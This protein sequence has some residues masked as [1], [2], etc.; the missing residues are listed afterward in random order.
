M[1]DSSE[2]D[3]DIFRDV[4]PFS[5]S[6]EEYEHDGER[7]SLYFGNGT[8]DVA[9]VDAQ[10]MP[11]SISMMRNKTFN[12]SLRSLQSLGS[13]SVTSRMTRLSKISRTEARL[14]Q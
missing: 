9:N 8:Y 3:D 14:A 4:D 13:P 12:S 7:T 10:S 5:S 1:D 11:R 2:L 6:D